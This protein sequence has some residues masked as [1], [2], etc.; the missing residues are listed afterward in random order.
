MKAGKIRAIAEWVLI[1]IAVLLVIFT[2][3]SVTFFDKNDR[4]LFGLKMYVCMSDSMSATDFSA[5][6]LV[7]V[8]NVEPSTLEKG[9]IIAYISE[10]EE[11][12]GKIITHKIR[13]IKMAVGAEPTFITY[14]TTTGMNDKLPV[15][16][17]QVVGEYAFSIPGIGNFFLFLQTITG[18]LLCVFLPMF[19]MFV[20]RLYRSIVLQKEYNAARKNGELNGEGG[21]AIENEEKSID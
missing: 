4:S 9:D 2:I 13:N 3:I 16:Y 15:T 6:D 14:G 20:L 18:F 10:D 1:G 7:L 21:E 11:S 17:S 12:E 8:K 19:I 5:G